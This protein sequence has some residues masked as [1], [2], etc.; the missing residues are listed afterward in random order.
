MTQAELAQRIGLPVKAV[1][2]I[3]RGKVPIMTETAVQ[4]ERALG[5]PTG[6]WLSLEANYQATLARL[7]R[8]VGWSKQI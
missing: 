3:I 5:I 4:L 8:T 2:E 1:R 6:I 7:L